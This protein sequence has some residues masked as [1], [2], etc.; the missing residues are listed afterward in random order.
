MAVRER[1]RQLSRPIAVY[2]TALIGLCLL[3]GR[4]RLLEP[5]HDNHYSHL[6]QAWLDGRLDHGGKPP[7]WCT[8]ERARAKKCRQHTYDDW[9]RVWTIELRDGSSF[10]GFPCKTSACEQLR[11]R[12]VE[13]WLVAGTEHELREVPRRDIVRRTDTWYVSFPPGPAVA[14]LP[15]VAIWGTDA[16]DVL[17]TCLFAAL[18]PVVMLLWFDRER[19][20]PNHDPSRARERWR[21]RG[22]EHLWAVA[23]WT[24]AS[25]AAFVGAHG[26]VWFTAQ[27]FGALCLTAYLATSW[28]AQRPV[29]AGLA[30]GLAVACRPHLAVAGLFFALEWR[31]ETQG[32]ERWIAAARFAGPLL[33][34]GLALMALN[35]ARFD[36]PFEF[37][38]RYL[39][40]RWQKRMQEVG[41]FSTEYLARNLR[42]AFSLAPVWRDN[43]PWNGHLPKVSLHGSSILIGA[44]WV[45]A[46]LW[47]RER[48]PQR[49]GLLLTAAAV[50]VPS[51]LYQNSGQ[52][53]FSYRFAIDW[54]PMILAAIVF[55][56][57]A[58]S[59]AFAVLVGLG[60]AWELY[61]A[62]LFG[63]R[64]GQLFVTDP[65]GWPFE[66]E[67]D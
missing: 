9:A 39:D 6:A 1:L 11:R 42:C 65:L 58:K 19:G 38:H 36:D 3:A 26:R 54:L 48:F 12:G 10:R 18:I 40:I 51:L 56:G 47:A 62:W 59:R 23:A 61:G 63:R 67:L 37:G 31:R 32:R 16:P 46:L 8:P 34:I 55:G 13:G 20:V 15:A 60:A 21:G 41:M 4:E 64:P 24:F 35:F 27:I 57:G 50:A 45:L 49:W 52:I 7:G 33:V 43:G 22:R 44:P 17:I 53:Q 2:L 66:A 30:L 28:K 25:P 14:M 29:L 5:S